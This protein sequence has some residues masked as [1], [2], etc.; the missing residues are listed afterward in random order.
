MCNNKN[1]HSVRLSLSPNS[2]PRY[3]YIVAVYV[4]GLS[5]RL[6]DMIFVC[7]TVTF[8]VYIWY[9]FQFKIR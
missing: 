5:R 9:N 8:C 6:F 7:S 3:C 2:V 4:Y 1:V